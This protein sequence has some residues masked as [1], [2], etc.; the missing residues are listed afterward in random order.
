MVRNAGLFGVQVLFSW[1]DAASVP[2]KDVLADIS[3]GPWFTEVQN[4]NRV[5]CEVFGE[6]KAF[7]ERDL[8]ETLNFALRDIVNVATASEAV[9]ETRVLKSASPFAPSYSVVSGLAFLLWGSNV[10]VTFGSTETPLK[11]ADIALGTGGA[12]GEFEEILLENASWEIAT[13]I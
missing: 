5:S 10:R 1:K 12:D 11:G 3:T 7:D 8:E 4:D 13:G 2:E 9:L 6:I